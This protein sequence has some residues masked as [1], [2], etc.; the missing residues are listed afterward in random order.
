MIEAE[1]SNF[2]SGEWFYRPDFCRKFFK[3][4]CG[5]ETGCTS[6]APN[7]R[8]YYN[9]RTYVYALVLKS[10]ISAGTSFRKVQVFTLNKKQKGT[11]PYISLKNRTFK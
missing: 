5:I 8:F 6:I 4:S 1:N 3:F 2:F 7:W 10:E 9:I 11:V